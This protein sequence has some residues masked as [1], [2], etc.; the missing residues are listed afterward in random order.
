MHEL[1]GRA[2]G[3]NSGRGG[4]ASTC[5]LSCSQLLPFVTLP[6]RP[7]P[8]VPGSGLGSSSSF[9]LSPKMASGPLAGSVAVALATSL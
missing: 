5:C 9:C 1:A 3:V 7:H 6:V 4:W 2:M 8:R